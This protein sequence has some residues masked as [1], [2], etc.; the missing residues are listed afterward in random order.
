MATIDDIRLA[1]I[2]E[3]TR[4]IDADSEA[5]EHIANRVNMR[6]RQ[7]EAAQAASDKRLR[8]LET[9]AYSQSVLLAE[10]SAKIAALEIRL[11]VQ[12]A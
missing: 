9:L 12:V 2:Q 11:S 5:V 4:N 7:M 1:M 3:R 8:E 10:Q 6:L